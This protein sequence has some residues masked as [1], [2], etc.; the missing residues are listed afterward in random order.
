[1]SR[2]NYDNRRFVS[3]SNSGNGEVSSETVFHYHQEGELVWGTYQGG[4]VVFGTLIAKV[5]EHDCL[6]IRY[7]HLSSDGELKTGI[8]KGTPTILP[9]GR[10]QLHEVWQWTSGDLS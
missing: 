5:D 8:C 3:V 6:D 1:M 9:D 4:M 7:H 2:I 10:L